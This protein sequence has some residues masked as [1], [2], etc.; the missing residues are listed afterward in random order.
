MSI[1]RKFMDW[2]F[3]IGPSFE[4]D[5]EPIVPPKEEEPGKHVVRIMIGS[6][7]VLLLLTDEEFCKSMM[8]ARSQLGEMT[9]EDDGGGVYGEGVED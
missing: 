4:D 2:L 5:S 8:R 7:E 9:I 6:K 3:S 1:I